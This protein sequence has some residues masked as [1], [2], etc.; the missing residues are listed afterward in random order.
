MENFVVV[1]NATDKQVGKGFASKDEAKTKRNELQAATKAGMP[2][3]EERPLE[4]AWAFRVSV[5]KDHPKNRATV[6]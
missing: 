2:K 1:D 3:L 4:S 5:G 6:H